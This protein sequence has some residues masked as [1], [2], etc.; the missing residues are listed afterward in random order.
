MKKNTLY[1]SWH[2]IFSPLSYIFIDISWSI[3]HTKMVQLSP[4]SWY[5]DV[6]KEG[7]NIAVR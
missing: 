5:E 2:L 3:G 1:V 4:E 7:C 6:S